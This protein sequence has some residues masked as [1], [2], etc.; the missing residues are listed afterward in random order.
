[1]FDFKKSTCV[2]LQWCEGLCSWFYWELFLMGLVLPHDDI[3]L[4]GSSLEVRAS[5]KTLIF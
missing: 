3:L 4:D 5:R 2:H 1:M